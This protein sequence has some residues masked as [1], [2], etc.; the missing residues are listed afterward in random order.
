MGA[1]LMFAL[2]AQRIARPRMRDEKEHAG[3]PDLI[4]TDS[5]M[6]IPIAKI[7][8]KINLCSTDTKGGNILACFYL[9]TAKSARI[10]SL[11]RCKC[12]YNFAV[13]PHMI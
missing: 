3:H 2:S 5:E 12:R 7:I 10:L 13:S 8:T 4:P 9:Y 1:L 11:V 6:I